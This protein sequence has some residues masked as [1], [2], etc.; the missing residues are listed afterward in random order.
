MGIH[1][2]SHRYLG[3]KAPSGGTTG[4]VPCA[5]GSDLRECSPLLSRALSKAKLMNITD[6]GEKTFVIQ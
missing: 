4:V 1:P 6:Q 2:K 3:M 5:H